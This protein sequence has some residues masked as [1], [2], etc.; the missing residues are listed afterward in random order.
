M[1]RPDVAKIDGL[2]AFVVTERLCFEIDVHLTRERI[3]HHERR[4]GKIVRSYQWID[5]AFK[6]AVSAQYGRHDQTVVFDRGGDGLGKR[7]AVTDTSRAAVA[8][9]MEA[10]LFEVGHQPRFLEVIRN[11]SRA[12]GEACLDP[13]LH[14]ESAFDSLFRQNACSKHDRGVRSIGATRNGGNHNRTVPYVIFVSVVG[15]RNA[16][17]ALALLRQHRR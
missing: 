15:Y 9:K 14:F 12:G 16:R 4:R 17:Y 5:S 10:Q 13:R 2:S 1:G 3:R 11:D 7:T 8:H 6:I